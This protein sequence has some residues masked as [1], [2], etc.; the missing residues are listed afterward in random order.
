MPPMQAAKRRTLWTTVV[1]VALLVVATT[2]PAAAKAG[3][4]AGAAGSDSPLLAAVEIG[5]GAGQ[6]LDVG[7]EVAD[8]VTAADVATAAGVELAL[9]APRSWTYLEDLARFSEDA[10]WR[11]EADVQGLAGGCLEPSAR[12]KTRVRGYELFRGVNEAV[13]VALSVDVS[14]LCV[15]PSWGD[16]LTGL[17]VTA[18]P[19]GYV[20]GPSMY[21]FAGFDPVNKSDPLG[22]AC[23]ECTSLNKKGTREEKAEGRSIVGGLIPG[24]GDVKDVQECT[25]G[26]DLIANKDLTTGEQVVTCVAVAAP[27]VITGA[28]IR[29]A[30][31]AVKKTFGGADEAVD[32]VEEVVDAADDVVFRG[33]TEGYPGGGSGVTFTSTDPGVAAVFGT[34]KKDLGTPVVEIVRTDDLAGVNRLPSTSPRLAEIEAEVIFDMSP[35]EFSKLASQVPLEN[36]VQALRQFGVDVPSRVGLGDLSQV[37]RE[38]KKLSP[39]QVQQFLN[40]VG[41]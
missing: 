5:L 27:W 8:V 16:Q 22:L 1:A 26:Q 14:T 38:L 10:K 25:S 29:G 24:V 2:R 3:P 7:T 35:A 32:A 13:D 23:P 36:A 31:R 21:A 20:D 4:A 37:L 40:A 17:F 39:E 19:L 30:W 11:L 9:E 28:A 41:E 33:T 6:Y 15:L 34:Q 12:L 18:D